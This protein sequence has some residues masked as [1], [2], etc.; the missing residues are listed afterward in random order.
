MDESNSSAVVKD[1]IAGTGAGAAQLV[2][3]FPFDTIKVKLQNMPRPAPGESPLYT[4]A[5]DA[6][7]KTVAE[8]GSSGLFKGMG[9]PLATVAI[10]NAIL[11]SVNGMVRRLVASWSNMPPGAEFS[12]PQYAICGAG[13]GMAVGV[14]AT[15]TELVKC[16]LQAQDHKLRIYSGP[17]DV[18]RKTLASEGVFGLFRGFAP[19]M[20]REIPGCALYFAGYEGSKQMFARASGKPVRELSAVELMTSGAIGGLSFWAIVGCG[21]L[22]VF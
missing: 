14:L 3:G 22:V 8:Q 18:I 20:G 1:L 11:F 4:S 10:F 2:V 21:V 12:V 9:V 5:V 16:R 13:A 15:P 7:R 19:T 6:L 17:T